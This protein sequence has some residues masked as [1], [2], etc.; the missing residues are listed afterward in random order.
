MTTASKDR[1]ERN[2]AKQFRARI[3]S[4]ID[5][6]RAMPNVPPSAILHL[7]ELRD[8]LRQGSD[9]MVEIISFAAITEVIARLDS[10]GADPF[11]F[12]TLVT[13]VTEHVLDVVT[14]RGLDRPTTILSTL[15]NRLR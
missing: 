12:L 13:F 2:V 9:A 7:E 3:T 10:Y 15:T 1:S 8:Q 11:D 14:Q 4:V 5:H 6:L